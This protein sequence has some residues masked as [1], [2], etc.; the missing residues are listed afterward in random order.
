MALR[1]MTITHIVML[2][3]YLFDVSRFAGALR[4]LRVLAEA[5]C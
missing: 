1:R 4:R 5:G 3:T 2:E